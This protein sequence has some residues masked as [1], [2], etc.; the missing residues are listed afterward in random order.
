[1][2]VAENIVNIDAVLQQSETAQ[3]IRLI[4]ADNATIKAVHLD[5]D[6]HYHH[7]DVDEV[8]VILEG[9]L[10]MDIQGQDSQSLSKGDII[11]VPAGR[12]HRTRT[13][14]PSKVLLIG[15]K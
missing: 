11:C 10:T 12:K 1:M 13:R 2:M 4:R 3:A 14:K 8:F 7:H 9:D 5:G 15:P 6:Y